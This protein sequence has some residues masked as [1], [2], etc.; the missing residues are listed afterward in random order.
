MLPLSQPPVQGPG[1][2]GVAVRSAAPL[3]PLCHVTIVAPRVKADLALP[4]DIPLPHILPGLLQAV[5]ETGGGA[6]AVPVWVLQRI[7]G[8]P[9]DLG[10]SL[11]ALGVLDGEVLYLRPRDAVLPPAV[12]D[13]VADVV[14]TSVKEGP[15]NWEKRH[16]RL[17]GLG[18]AV[19]LLLTGTVALVAAGPPWTVPAVLAAVLALLLLGAGGAV[20]RALGDS[21]A[22]ALIGYT[23]LPYGF[24]AGLL[25]PAGLTDSPAGFGAP[26][27][28]SG[29]A[30]TVFVATAGGIAVA[31]GV[32]GFMGT[33][34]AAAAGA[35]AAGVVMVSGASPAGVAAV[36]ASILLAL[37]SAVPMLSFRIAR[38]PMPTMPTN[39]EELRAD[40]QR[41]DGETIRERTGRAQR[42]ATGMVAGIALTAL[43][44]QVYLLLDG[45]WIAI[46]TALVLAAVLVMRARVFQGLGQRLW[47]TLG[48]VAG[49]AVFAVGQAVAGSGAAAITV[50]VALLWAAAVPAGLGLWL[51]AGRPSPFWGRAGDIIEV[52]LVV[53]LF[54][55]ALGVLDV[56]AWVRGLAG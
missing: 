26:H 44:T 5:G 21:A 37:G 51:P 43:V 8:A 54:P 1:P 55:L 29:F 19:A 15:S 13:D 23:A 18:A 10:Q 20:S 53:A 32:P 12:F 45:R 27:L 48:G 6:A 31:D 35:A 34:V 39:A 4:A 56:Y 41:V 42:Y 7:G 9:L 11:G 52:L 33:G 28:L 24:L 14:A 38:L 22:G 46:A 17:T 40:N 25:A 2:Q 16:T 36:T 49:L 47:L 30:V 3:P 50:V